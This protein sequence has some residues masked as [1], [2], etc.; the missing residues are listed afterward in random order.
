VVKGDEVNREISEVVGRLLNT[1]S[2][3]IS[4]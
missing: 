4:N 2:T 3:S 1:R